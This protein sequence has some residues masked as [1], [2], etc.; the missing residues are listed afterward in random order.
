MTA[1][2][3]PGDREN[4]LAA[5]MD[6]YLTK[7]LVVKKITDCLDKW[8]AKP[9]KGEGKMMQPKPEEANTS[10]Q[11]GSNKKEL[12]ERIGGNEQAADMI[13][14][15]AIKTLPAEIEK[16]K[17]ALEAADPEQIGKCAHSIKGMAG[18]MSC[19]LLHHSAAELDKIAKA[20]RL[21]DIPEQAKD[22][23]AK[24]DA[25]LKAISSQS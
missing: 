17:N 7:P 16:L 5:G 6:D 8:L 23:L 9:V 18:N 24:A 21:D 20:H 10:Q 4:C 2:A 12:L 22:V 13:I 1:H 15:V 14:E 19:D 3:L 11:S 25:V